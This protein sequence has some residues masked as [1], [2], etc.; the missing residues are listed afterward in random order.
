MSSMSIL[1]VCVA[2]FTLIF[3]LLSILSLM[4]RA[5]TI[6]FPLVVEEDSTAIAAIT[7]TYHSIYPDS[8]V[9]RIEEITK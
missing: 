7:T 5:L 2:A 4:M 8:K 9:T 1:T 3:L 6:L